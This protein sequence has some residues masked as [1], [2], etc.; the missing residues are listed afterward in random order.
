MPAGI[1]VSVIG[2]PPVVVFAVIGQVSPEGLSRAEYQ[3]NS[4]VR[5]GRRR[6]VIDLTAADYVSSEGVG[7]AFH[8]H[9]ILGSCGGRLVVVKGPPSVMNRIGRFIIPAL[10]VVDTKAEA[11][12]ML[13]VDER[14]PSPA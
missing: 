1:E 12:E 14:S 2:E 11:L 3:L 8:Y 10:T 9:M 13:G 6:V 7:V 5:S 4:F